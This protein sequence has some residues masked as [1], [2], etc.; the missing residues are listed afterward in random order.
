MGNFISALCAVSTVASVFIGLGALVIG[1]VGGYFGTYLINTK[2]GCSIP[3]GKEEN[4]AKFSMLTNAFKLC[5]EIFSTKSFG[6][7]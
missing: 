4:V 6:K 7:V 2:N 5:N 1:L 3:F